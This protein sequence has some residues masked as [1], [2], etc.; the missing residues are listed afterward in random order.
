MPIEIERRFLVSNDEWRAAATSS[1]WYRQSYLS[2]TPDSSIRVR[3]SDD[4]GTI[5][6]KG[7]RKGFARDEFEY[8]IPV[9][10]AEHMLLHL[11]VTPI[12]EKVRH[13]VE[14]AGLTWEVDVYCGEA[15]GL[16]LAEVELDRIDQSF[17][18]PPWVG[19]EVTLNPSYRSRGIARGL[20]R[21][22]GG[23]LMKT[24]SGPAKRRS[25]S[26]RRALAPPPPPP[27]VA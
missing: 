25:A 11:C 12:I 17:A 1:R 5:T 24:G 13:W 16:V 10:H 14:H 2:Q 9:H 23:G 26:A 6:V 19:A 8:G 15:S 3:R 18:L 22:A 27:P 21:D 20:W 7:P 4:F